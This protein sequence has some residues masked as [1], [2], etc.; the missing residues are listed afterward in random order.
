ME[1]KY[2]IGTILQILEESRFSSEEDLFL[3]KLK[4]RGDDGV[5]YV[6]SL[7]DEFQPIQKNN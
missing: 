6:I 2:S 5:E 3:Q 1:S 7:G 4:V